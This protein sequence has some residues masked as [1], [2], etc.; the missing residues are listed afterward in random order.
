[1]LV[2][3]CQIP[4]KIPMRI[5][6]YCESNAAQDVQTIGKRT[7]PKSAV[8]FA[9]VHTIL[10]VVILLLPRKLT[11]RLYTEKI[12]LLSALSAKFALDVTRR[13]LVSDVT[14]VLFPKLCHFPR[15]KILCYV[16]CV[17]IITMRISSARTVRI[18]GTTNTFNMPNYRFGGNKS[19]D[20]KREVASASR[21]WMILRQQS[22]TILL[23]HRQP[24]NPKIHCP[25][26]LLSIQ[27]G[28]TQRHRNGD[29]LKWTC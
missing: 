19:I 3:N 24:S 10:V 15:E 21:E 28:T 20:P 2:Q 22:I 11:T 14:V 4:K 6:K 12:R 1:M 26:V 29:L 13:T 17:L 18:H 7:K 8:V 5:W 9:I 23:R 27:C 25:K 16:P